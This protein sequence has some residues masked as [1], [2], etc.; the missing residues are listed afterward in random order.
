RHP[1]FIRAR[2]PLAIGD[3]RRDAL[4]GA[5]HAG[6]TSQMGAGR[7]FARDLIQGD[8]VLVT[9]GGTGIGKAIALAAAECGARVAIASRRRDNPDP[10][11]ARIERETRA[12]T[13][14]LL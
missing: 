11:A 10:R 14:W 7:F 9:G 13:L 2:T 3:A 6:K 8:R 4:P 12:G 1:S 5:Q